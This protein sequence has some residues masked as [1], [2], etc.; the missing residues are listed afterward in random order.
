[1]KHK[2]TLTFVGLF[3]LLIY[4]VVTDRVV[5]QKPKVISFVLDEIVV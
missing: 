1:M 3:R 2:I 4:F 5:A